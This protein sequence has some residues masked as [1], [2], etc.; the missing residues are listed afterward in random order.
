MTPSVVKYSLLVAFLVGL[1]I[2]LPD[3][4]ML[5]SFTPPSQALGAIDKRNVRKIYQ[6]IYLI[7]CLQ[8]KEMHLSWINVKAIIAVAFISHFS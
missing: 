2:V 1:R 6:R 5:F 8:L 7:D 3:S 4:F